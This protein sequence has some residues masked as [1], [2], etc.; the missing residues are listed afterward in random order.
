LSL[1]A[2]PPEQMSEISGEAHGMWEVLFATAAETGARAG[3]LYALEVKD[4]DFV[5]NL[6][7]IHRAVWEGK[8][9]ST[10]TRNATRAIDVQ[11]SLIAMLK[12]H[13]N[14]RDRGIGVP[15]EERDDS[16]RYRTNSA[17]PKV[18]CMVSGMG[19]CRS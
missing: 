16:T 13:L 15:V 1:S 18:G 12:E 9:Q 6:I 5:R 7:H 8:K 14:G 17:Y 2:T 10:K 4:I 11:A 19:E 3:E